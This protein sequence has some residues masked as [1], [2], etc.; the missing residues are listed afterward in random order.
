MS[1]DDPLT[2]MNDQIAL[3]TRRAEIFA[4]LDDL[5]RRP[6]TPRAWWRRRKTRRLA[7][8]WRRRA[9][10]YQRIAHDLGLTGH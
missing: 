7:R 5:E 4:A 10:H 8:E 1:Q 6:L 3:A 9:E 2:V